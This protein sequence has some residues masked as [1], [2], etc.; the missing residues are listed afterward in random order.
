MCETLPP[1]DCTAP[2]DIQLP[3]G[4]SL[5]LYEQD[6]VQA[7]AGDGADTCLRQWRTC[8]DGTW[9]DVNGNPSNFT[10]TYPSC[11]VLPPTG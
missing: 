5:T 8:V 6:E 4:N 1:A 3:H 7:E 10:Y 11:T 2:G 9:M